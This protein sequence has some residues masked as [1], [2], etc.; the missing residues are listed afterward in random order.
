MNRVNLNKIEEFVEEAKKEK[1]YLK[2]KKGMNSNQQIND[3]IKRVLITCLI[4]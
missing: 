2:G 1:S 4:I 3:E